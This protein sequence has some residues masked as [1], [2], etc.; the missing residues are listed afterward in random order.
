M[1]CVLHPAPIIHAYGSVPPLK[2][3]TRA[4]VGNCI[5]IRPEPVQNPAPGI[6]TT[7]IRAVVAPDVLYTNTVPV[8]SATALSVSPFAKLAAKL[9]C[10]V[11]VVPLFV[12]VATTT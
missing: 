6:V 5:P 1:K 9:A 3:S 8:A 4:L 7:P 10:V 11:I 2:L 12:V